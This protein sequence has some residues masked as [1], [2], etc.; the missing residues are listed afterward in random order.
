MS[1]GEDEAN[2]R[3][4]SL[5]ICNSDDQSDKEKRYLRLL[6]EQQVDGIIFAAKDTLSLSDEEQLSHAKIP[7]VLVDRGKMKRSQC[8][9][10]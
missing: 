2:E 4:Y 5:I 6:E 1:G 10:R 9:F 7:F 3:E 8:F